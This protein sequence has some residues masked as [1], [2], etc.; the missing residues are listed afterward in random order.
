MHPEVGGARQNAF[1][2]RQDALHVEFFELAGVPVDPR[3]RQLLAEPLGV[4]VVRLD[5][6][7]PLEE[8]RLVETFQ[9]VLNRLGRALGIRELLANGRLPRLPDLARGQEGGVD[10]GG[11]PANSSPLR[12]AASGAR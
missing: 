1:C 12:I 2:E 6:N 3:E 11:A 4:A 9:L 8:E 7:R 5:V 10:L